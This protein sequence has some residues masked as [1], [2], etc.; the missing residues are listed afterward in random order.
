MTH[1]HVRNPV[2]RRY[3]KL[4]Y[5]EVHEL[6][7]DLYHRVRSS[8]WIPEVNI[9]IGRGGLFVL[10]A[11]Q[12]FFAAEGMRIPY[13]LVA[14]DRYEGLESAGRPVVRSM[15]DVD[16]RGR[17]VLVVDDVAD[18]GDSM[19]AVK[20]LMEARG[21]AAVRTA[22][23]HVKPWSKI[24]PDYYV[25]ETD[26]WIIYPWELYETIAM[27]IRELASRGATPEESYEELVSRAHV[28][29][30]ELRNFSDIT[31]HSGSLAG[32]A[33]L[34]LDQLIS[35]HGDAGKP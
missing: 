21:V 22:T 16:I 29:P 32:R 19:L 9:C 25:A 18:Y 8:G 34:I 14:V 26:A 31:R 5:E 3:L 30:Q 23:L 17:R 15:G 28:T 12:D 7:L 10:R 24:I 11:L 4:S 33:G 1:P 35:A 27:I 6:A 20:E 2:A 13:Q